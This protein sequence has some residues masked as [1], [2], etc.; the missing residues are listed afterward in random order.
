MIEHTTFR[1]LAA[2]ANFLAVDRPD[3][4]YAA[5]EICRFIAKPSELALQALKRLGRYLRLHPEWSS[6]F[7]SRAYLPLRCIPTRTGPGACARASPRQ[8]AA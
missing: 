2:R 5:K 4:I 8:A 1:G 6:R 7:L 3:I